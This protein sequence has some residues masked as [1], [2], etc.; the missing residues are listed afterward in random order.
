M[1]SHKYDY[2]FKILL[3]GED[4]V[5]KV[6]FLLRYTDGIL[7]TNNLNTIVKSN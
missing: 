1:T 2:L 6:P 5:G 3:I 4:R 7:T